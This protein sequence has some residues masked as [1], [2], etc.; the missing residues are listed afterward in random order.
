[1]APVS[2]QTTIANYQLRPRY[3]YVSALVNYE[4]LTPSLRAVPMEEGF[5]DYDGFL[6]ALNENGFQGVAAYEMCS[7]LQGGGSL[8]NL[9]HYAK[10]FLDYMKNH[11]VQPTH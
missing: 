3:R 6:R 4:K 8:E 5:I 9:D 2:V 10:R 1:M 7:P 11:G